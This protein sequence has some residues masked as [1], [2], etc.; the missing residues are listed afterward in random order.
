[1]AGTYK[2]TIS[3]GKYTPRTYDVT[4]TDEDLS[5]TAELCPY[6]D[7]NGDGKISTVDVGIVN[8]YVKGTSTLEGYQLD[9]AET[10]GDKKISTVDVGMIN[11]HAKNIKSIW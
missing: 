3:G 11:S 7:V 5:L 8:S 6:G 4:I 9:V 10:S 1:M 2:F